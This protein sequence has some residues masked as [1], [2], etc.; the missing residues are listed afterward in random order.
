MKNNLMRK[1]KSFDITTEQWMIM[2]RLFEE[3][4]ISQKELSER[5]LKDQGAL[6]RTLDRIEKKGLVK[7]RVNPYDRRSF[8]IY[9]TDEGQDVR[10]QIVPIAEKCIEDAVKGF[11]EEEVDT[12]TTLLRRVIFNL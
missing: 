12:L 10:D 1:I 5:T 11:T 8:L 3:G 6:T 9:L 7:R 4:G 2:N